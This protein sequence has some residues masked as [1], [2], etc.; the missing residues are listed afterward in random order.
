MQQPSYFI[1]T[2]SSSSTG[3]AIRQSA[4][5]ALHWLYTSTRFVLASCLSVT[6]WSLT[7]ATASSDAGCVQ[8]RVVANL[9]DVVGG[10]VLHDGT[11]YETSQQI[12]C[13]NTHHELAVVRPVHQK[14]HQAFAHVPA[15]LHMPC[16]SG[17]Q[18][19]GQQWFGQ[20]GWDWQFAGQQGLVQ[21]GI[22]P[23]RL[24]A[25]NSWA[26]RITHGCRSDALKHFVIRIPATAGQCTV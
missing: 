26:N 7:G 10:H 6:V 24:T 13:H 11:E 8:L 20:Q 4:N 23:A 17:Q 18:C 19:L 22:G 16:C 2:L 15:N 9:V 12:S 3:P 1:F 14:G 21:Q 5:L 25:R